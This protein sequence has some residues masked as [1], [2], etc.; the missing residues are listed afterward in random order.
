VAVREAQAQHLGVGRAHRRH[1]PLGEEAVRRGAPLNHG[2]PSSRSSS[3]GAHRTIQVPLH[4]PW[5]PDAPRCGA[6][7]TAWSWILT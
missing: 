4:S 5:A 2:A 1:V 3:A 7:L 6:D